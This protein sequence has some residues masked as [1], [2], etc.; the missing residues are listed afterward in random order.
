[1]TTLRLRLKERNAETIFGAIAAE[2]AKDGVE[3]IDPRPS[4]RFRSEDGWLTR[5]KPDK[6]QQE[7]IEFGLRIGKAVSALD[8]GQ[9]RR[10]QEGTVLAWKVLRARTNAFAVV[11]ALAGEKGGAGGRQRSAKR[12]MIFDLISRVSG[13]DD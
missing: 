2:M 11:G 13:E 9:Y 8:I 6:E 1:M 7:D 5:H 12:S 10:R 4:L 3:L